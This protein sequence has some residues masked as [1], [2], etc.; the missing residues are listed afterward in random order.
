MFYIELYPSHVTLHVSNNCKSKIIA[1][2]FDVTVLYM[3]II[4]PKTKILHCTIGA[5]TDYRMNC[6]S[7]LNFPLMQY[8]LAGRITAG[9]QKHPT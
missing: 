4:L 5:Q 2:Q 7:F 1:K 6:I 8:C 9:E 3:A